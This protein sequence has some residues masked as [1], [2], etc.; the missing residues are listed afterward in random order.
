MAKKQTTKN[1][2]RACQIVLIHVVLL[3]VLFSNEPLRIEG[4]HTAVYDAVVKNFLDARFTYGLFGY[5]RAQNTRV[6]CLVKYASGRSVEWSPVD[7][8]NTSFWDKGHEAI[9]RNWLDENIGDHGIETHKALMHDAAIYASRKLEKPDDKVVDVELYKTVES[10]PA[11]GSNQSPAII[12]RTR[13]Y[14][15][16][17][18]PAT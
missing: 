6:T 8:E 7:L 13:L 14:S 2:K 11:P 15:L 16:S 18:G 5:P 10:I 12:E 3:T 9:M 1:L 4:P 17:G